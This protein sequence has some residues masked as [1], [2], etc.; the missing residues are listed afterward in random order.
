MNDIY[1]KS[2]NYK[3]AYLKKL[4]IE[5]RSRQSE[6]YYKYT[7]P[8]Y[9][10]FRFHECG[11]K[12]RILKGAPRTAKTTS[13]LHDVVKIMKGEHP[14]I[15]KYEGI[16]DLKKRVWVMATTFKKV[17]EVLMPMFL[18]AIP[19]VN[20]LHVT[21]DVRNNKYYIE[22]NNG[23]KVLFKSQEESIGTITS[24]DATIILM[25]ERIEN[26][27]WREQIRTRI[28]STD[29]LLLF[30]MDSNEEDEWIEGLKQLDYCETFQFELKD[31]AKNLP[32]DEL[33]RLETELD[34][35]AK[36]KLLSGKYIDRNIK[37][38]FTPD[39]WNTSNYVEI[40]PQKFGVIHGEVCPDEEGF[41]KV[42]KIPEP[43]VKYLVGYDPAGGNSRNSH[44]LHVF[45]E[46]G[47]QCASMLSNAFHYVNAPEMFLI[48]ILKWY[49][50]A[51]FVSENREHGR[52]IVHKV[53]DLGYFNIYSDSTWKPMGTK[54]MKLVDFGIVT[55]EKSKRD[56]TNNMLDY[57]TNS[58]IL[59][60]DRLTKIQLERF[61]EDFRDLDTQKTAGKLHGTR[62][63]NEP[64]L[65]NSDDDLVMSLFFVGRAML[66]MG[67]FANIQYRKYNMNG[68]RK[69]DL[70]I[71]DL[72]GIKLYRTEQN[73]VYNSL[74]Y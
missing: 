44:G 49:N 1:T 3:F 59:L 29:G 72:V 28:I 35:I 13:A 71:D 23:W 11:K 46:N 32:Q 31:N 2:D 67:Y 25:D 73:T 43:N 54:V 6:F 20:I 51:V 5:L 14:F 42:F 12:I 7:P 65:K 16:P 66:N 47:E 69:K 55:D 52:Y 38:I 62:A 64:E 45:D 57:I 53:N 60:H 41:I 48:P 4:V 68:A 17:T 26:E 34:D 27:D 21:N 74:G 9:K 56:M 10:H 33:D 22:L 30:T 19:K 50:N 63:M 58:R 18:E 37:Y 70:T 39:I 36:E 8:S 40:I 24:A 61:V 15:T